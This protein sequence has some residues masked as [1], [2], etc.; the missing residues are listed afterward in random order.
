MLNNLREV[1]DVRRKMICVAMSTEGQY[2]MSVAA[3]WESD[4]SR[5]LHVDAVTNSVVIVF[6]A[7]Q[8]DVGRSRTVCEQ[9]LVVKEVPLDLQMS[10]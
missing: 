9:L 6:S 3:I 4:P 8:C 10:Y 2:S 5:N 1:E 7:M